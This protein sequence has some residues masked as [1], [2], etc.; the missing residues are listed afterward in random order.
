M[1]DFAK[2]IKLFFRETTKDQTRLVKFNIFVLILMVLWFASEGLNKF[3]LS[4]INSI[5]N[6]VVS[7]QTSLAIDKSDN[8]PFFIY[9]ISFVFVFLIC[10]AIIH[11]HES[12][13]N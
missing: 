9:I 13:D 5:G 2:N 12:K 8:T 4:V 7:P 11:L 3:V 10:I 6:I 1:G